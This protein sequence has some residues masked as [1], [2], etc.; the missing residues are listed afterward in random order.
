MDERRRLV[1]S[2][3]VQGIGFRMTA[4]H[5]AVDLPVSG[6]VRNLD[7]GDV[8]LVVEGDAKDIETLLD[9]LREQFEGLIRT[10][11]QDR[12]PSPLAGMPSRVPGRGIRVV[13]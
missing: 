7:D 5:L 13:Y 1:F 8:E 9:R 4:V 11:T 12:S 6:T 3:R 10:V 2:G